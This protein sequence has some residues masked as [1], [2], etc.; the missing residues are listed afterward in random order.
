M[1]PDDPADEL[2]VA[3]DHFTNAVYWLQAH[4]NYTAAEALTEALADWTADRNDAADDSPGELR[5]TL[6]AFLTATTD[7]AAADA[8]A[9]ALNAWSS[10]VSAEHHQSTPFQAPLPCACGG[11]RSQP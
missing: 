11:R 10:A 8:L 3:F 1:S 5:A 7:L 6:S 2:L 4:T 9:D